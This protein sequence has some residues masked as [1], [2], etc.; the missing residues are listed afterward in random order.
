MM[1]ADLQVNAVI[2]FSGLVIKI[3][4]NIFGALDF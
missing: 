4:V 3:F 1:K 2:V